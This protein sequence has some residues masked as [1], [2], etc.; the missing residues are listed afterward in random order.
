MVAEYAFPESVASKTKFCGYLKRPI[1]KSSCNGG[2]PHIL[3]TTGG[4][5]DG[6]NIIEAYL[7]RLCGLPPHTALRTTVVFR[8]Q[9]PAPRRPA[10]VERLGYLAGVTRRAC[11]P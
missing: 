1:S 8:P 6:S 4:R 3:V 11:H 9:P 2:P 5:D 10:H 7:P